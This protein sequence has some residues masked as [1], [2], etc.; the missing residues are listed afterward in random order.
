MNLT[1]DR[2]IL[3]N[4]KGLSYENLLFNNSNVIVSGANGT[5]KSTVMCG[6]Y[7]LTSDCS[8]SLVSN[9]AIFP[10]NIEECTPSVEVVANID[11]KQITLERRIKRTIKKSRIEGTADAVSFSSTYLVN[12][13]EYGLRDFKQKLTEYGITD[14]FLTLSHPD[15]FL[16]QKRD[17]MRKV[18]F[19]M[20]SDVTDLQIAQQ[21]D[22]VAEATELLKNYTFE[23]AQS[24][25]KASLRKIREIYGKDGELLRAK[26]SGLEE[27]KIDLDFAE[28]ELLKNSIKER[29]AKNEESRRV[30]NAINSEIL[31]LDTKRNALQTEL[32]SLDEKESREKAELENKIRSERRELEDK[33]Y[34]LDRDIRRLEGE[35]EIYEH[36]FESSNAEKKRLEKALTEAKALVLDEIKNYCPVCNRKYPESKIE[37]IRVGFVAEKNEKIAFLENQ[38]KEN[39]SLLAIKKSEKADLDKRLAKAVN[40]RTELKTVLETP[41]DVLDVNMEIPNKYGDRRAE[42]KAE[43]EKLATVINEKKATRPNAEALTHEEQELAGQLRDCEIQL[44][45]AD[46]NSKIDSQIEEL[47]RQ[48]VE[49][50]QNIANNEKVLYQLDLILRKKHE[51]LSDSINKHFK[52]VKWEFWEFLKNG[53]LRDTVVAKVN[54]KPFDS[55]L[56][57]AMQVRAK[58]DIIQGLQN[59]YGESYPV[60]VDGAE[61]LDD[62]SMAQIDMPCQMV[63]LKVAD[64]NLFVREI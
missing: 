1:I 15:M 63:Y 21:M 3:H 24:M 10:L 34:S 54:G 2:I 25:Q 41:V 5:G 18:L 4:F 13:V 36:A 47:Q 27:A 9:P 31:E 48:Q 16:S 17:E 33:A 26:I 22:G 19:G 58:L 12:S 45:K 38:L 49:F 23:E 62:N 39:A 40:D 51:V 20:V 8:E 44:S 64:N 59:Y 57:T 50:E 43:I 32:Y 6:W 55:S 11:G 29:Q 7:W 61:S 46:M 14:R 42:L 53:E 37:K 52:L 56:N 28:L 30:Y 60:F 35:K